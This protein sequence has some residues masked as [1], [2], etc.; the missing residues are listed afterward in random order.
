MP[1]S[2]DEYDEIY[3]GYPIYWGDM[4][5]AVYTFLESEDWNGKTVHPFRTHDGSG[6]GRTESHVRSACRGADV[7][8]GLAVHGDTVDSAESTVRSWV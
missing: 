2:L 6:L 5:M 8:K 3:L 7:T 4:P 1:D